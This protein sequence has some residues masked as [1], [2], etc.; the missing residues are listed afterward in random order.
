M[1]KN[2]RNVDK[3]G[4]CEM[5]S[6]TFRY[7]MVSF[8]I[9]LLIASLITRFEKWDDL[10]RLSDDNVDIK[11][12]LKNPIFEEGFEQGYRIRVKEIVREAY[13]TKTARELIGKDH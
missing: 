9:G 13:S 1:V 10:N 7:V 5:N 4:T 11:V 6:Q 2:V 8:F 12:K 3:K